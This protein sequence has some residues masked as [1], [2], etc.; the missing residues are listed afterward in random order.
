[1]KDDLCR[2]IDALRPEME[3]ISAAIH[4]A[5][6][7]GFEEVKASGWLTEFLAG[8]GLSV[9]RGVAGLPTAFR[10]ERGE[11]G[12]PSLAFLAEYDA[13]PGLGH[14]CGHNL[15]GTAS[16]AAA[17]ALAECWPDAPGRSA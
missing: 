8:H 16:C 12:A 6:E 1:M 14:G 5:P 17:I 15:I 10:A 2:R 7:V 11:G 13:L 4:G 9:R 3:R